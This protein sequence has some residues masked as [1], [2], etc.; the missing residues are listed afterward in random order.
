M[1]GIVIADKIAPPD[2]EEYAVVMDA[3]SRAKAQYH[4]LRVAAALEAQPAPEALGG[5][6]T[7]LLAYLQRGQ[8]RR[9]E[10][11]NLQIE[12][13]AATTQVKVLEGLLADYDAR[14]DAFTDAQIA[15]A[16]DPA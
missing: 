14:N 15:A 12:L 2:S 9:V 5:R 4:S 8:Q 1:S 10:G 13:E 16:K 11:K 3:L 6:Y 7:N